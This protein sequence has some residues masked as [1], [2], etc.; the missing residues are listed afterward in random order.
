MSF[1]EGMFIILDDACEQFAKDEYPFKPTLK[2]QIR[3]FQIKY[4]V[5]LTSLYS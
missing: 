4:L 5:T 1:L 2:L 3:V